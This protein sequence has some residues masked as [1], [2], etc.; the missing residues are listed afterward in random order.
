LASLADKTMKGFP[1]LCPAGYHSSPR[2]LLN[3]ETSK[4]VLLRESSENICQRLTQNLTLLIFV[5]QEAI[6]TMWLATWKT[7]RST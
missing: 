4:T 7:S 1:F 2:E 6:P 5:L 3:N